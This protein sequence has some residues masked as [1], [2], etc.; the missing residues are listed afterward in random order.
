[1]NAQIVTHQII[2]HK[3]WLTKSVSV[4]KLIMMM[5]NIQHVYHVLV[6]VRH[7]KGLSQ[8]VFPVRPPIFTHHNVIYLKLK[9]N[10]VA[11]TGVLNVIQDLINA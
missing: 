8:F 4:M 11:F 2:E 6:S 7:V 1:M 10:K 9:Y 3:M 5:E